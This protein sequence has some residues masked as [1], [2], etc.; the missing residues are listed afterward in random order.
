MTGIEVSP[1]IQWRSSPMTHIYY[2]LVHIGG[3]CDQCEAGAE[4]LLSILNF[5][6]GQFE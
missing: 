2:L 6:D 1:Y 3:D 5:V 4:M